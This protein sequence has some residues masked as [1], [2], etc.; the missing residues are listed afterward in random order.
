MRNGGKVFSYS[1]SATLD[2][3]TASFINENQRSPIFLRYRTPDDCRTFELG[4]FVGKVRSWQ[5]IAIGPVLARFLGCVT[6]SQY[7]EKGIITLNTSVAITTPAAITSPYT[8]TTPAKKPYKS[9]PENYRVLSD[10]KYHKVVADL[11]AILL[12]ISTDGV[13]IN[14]P[15]GR[16]STTTLK[17][18]ASYLRNALETLSKAQ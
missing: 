17:S 7:Q 1:R 12:D 16:I 13:G 9:V 11:E 4:N 3:V 15:D 18:W 8:Q 6:M 10:T 2:E 5:A 14:T